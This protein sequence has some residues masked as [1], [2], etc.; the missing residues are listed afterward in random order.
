MTAS[1][2]VSQKNGNI[3]ISAIKK[4]LSFNPAIFIDKT[5]CYK[6]K[7]SSVRCIE[8]VIKFMQKAPVKLM[9]QKRLNYLL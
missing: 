6:L 8:N 3:I 5:N 7:V 4:Y 1:F 9:G 2:D